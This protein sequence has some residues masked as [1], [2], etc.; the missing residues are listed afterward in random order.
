M[1][2][3]ACAKAGLVKTDLFNEKFVPRKGDDS[4]ISGKYVTIGGTKYMAL[5]STPAE[6]AET[7]LIVDP[8][9]MQKLFGVRIDLS[10]LSAKN[11]QLASA[12]VPTAKL[13]EN[14]KVPSPVSVSQSGKT[15]VWSSNGENDI[16]GYRIYN[17]G[18]KIASIKAGSALSYPVGNG[19][20]YVTAVDVAGQESPPSNTAV[21]EPPPEPETPDE[22]KQPVQTTPDTAADVP[23]QQP[24]SQDSQDS[25]VEIQILHPAVRIH[26]LQTKRHNTNSST[27]NRH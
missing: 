10:V 8:N 24:D 2:S 17:G 1:P 16:V 19:S 6:F 3:D 18:N 22:G 9:Y 26:S 12:L 21:R 5:D 4:L 14:G 11:S 15:L 27:N 25:Q 23:K 7:G 20:Y 13:S